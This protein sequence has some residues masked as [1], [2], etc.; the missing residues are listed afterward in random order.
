MYIGLIV[1][2]HYFCKIL[3]KLEFSRQVLKKS[4]N[5]KFRGILPVEADLSYADGGQIDRG[6]DRHD[7]ANFRLSQFANAP[8]NIPSKGWICKLIHCLNGEE[9]RQINSSFWHP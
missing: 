7:K 4:S 9:V 2:T 3:M 1:N 5:V 8:K 6:T